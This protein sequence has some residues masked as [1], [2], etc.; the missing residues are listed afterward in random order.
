MAPMRHARGLG[1]VAVLALCCVLGADQGAE[2]RRVHRA[3]A[4]PAPPLP[5]EF[6][7]K[8]NPP[9]PIRFPDTR[10]EPVA[11]KHIE[12]WAADDHAAAYATFLASCRALVGSAKTSRDVRPVYRALLEICREARAA[13]AL[14]AEPARQFFERHFSAVR[15][16][17]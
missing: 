6:T 9:G 16:S 2:A 12:G 1:R 4:R 10:F 14:A 15:V 13:G 5:P 7:G 3:K 17:R 11:F 8:P